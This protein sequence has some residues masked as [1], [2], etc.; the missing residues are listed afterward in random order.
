[1]EISIQGLGGREWRNGEENGNWY[2][3]DGSI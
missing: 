3:I 1:M 2:I